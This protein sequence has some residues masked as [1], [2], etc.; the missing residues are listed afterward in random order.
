MSDEDGLVERLVRGI[1]DGEQVTLFAGS[2][3]TAAAVPRAAGLLQL[4]DRYAVERGESTNLPWAL[5]HAREEL[6]ADAGTLATY[7]A[8]RRVFA[9]RVSGAEFDVVAQEAVLEAYSPADRATSP[10]AH[11]GR[12][13]RVDRRLGERVENDHD[14]WRLPPGVEA[15]GR[16]LAELPEEFGNRILTTNFDPLV[17]I[18]IRRAGGYAT[19]LPLGPDGKL[20]RYRVADDSVR[21]YHLHGYWRPTADLDGQRLLHA[22]EPLLHRQ[23]GL[24]AR[25]ADLVLGDVVCVVGY[26]GWDELFVEA[27]RQLADER[28]VSVVWALRRPG[29]DADEALRARLGVDVTFFHGVDTDH[30]LPRLANRLG[31]PAAP[32][33][34]VSRY[35]HRHAEWERE[36]LSQPYARP[37]AELLPL[38]GQLDRRFGWRPGWAGEPRAPS[39][40]FWPVR[41]RPRA[42]LIHAVQ[43]MVAG[44]LAARGADVVVC[45]DDFGVAD[46]AAVSQRFQADLLRWCRG[47]AGLSGDA[48]G[49]SPRFVS[50]EEFVEHPSDVDGTALLRP[51]TPW[52]VAREFYGEHNPSLYRLLVAARI[53]PDVP[54]RELASQAGAIVQA[55]LHR[56]ANRLLTPLTVWA[57]LNHLLVG[58]ATG[59]V[60]TLGGH[61]ERAF[62]EQWREVFHVGVNQ[63]YSPR[64]KALNSES[65]MLRWTTVAELREAME[66]ACALP[67]WDA[68]GHYL[69]WLVQNALLLPRYLAG[70]EV[71]TV[72]RYRLD[73]WAAVRAAIRHGV[74]VLDLLAEE[75]SRLYLGP[76]G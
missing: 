19:S 43:A 10:V 67:R 49:I 46:R 8:Y 63:L 34:T 71:P 24:A 20:A 44:A 35:R 56:E 13:Q 65:R 48:A 12:W 4:A 32:R 33:P 41:L 38:L 26:S 53:V 68:D 27:L 25:V 64:I 51:T 14:A 36:L 7:L 17:E 6:G 55:L 22:P 28:Q 21:V 11:R 72:R 31:I 50:L 47:A 30:L 15:V 42:S 52:A 29:P 73:S 54:P 5:A 18:A 45:L 76:E 66:R 62:W 59:D 69:P 75:V 74:P 60:M 57:Y 1:A 58:R 39:L 2:G 37:P 40:L 70:E 9:D 23:A 61:D 3:L 16:L